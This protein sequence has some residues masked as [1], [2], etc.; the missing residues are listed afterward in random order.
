MVLNNS[1]ALRL[2]VAAGSGIHVMRLPLNI[3]TIESDVLAD[4][5][6]K[7]NDL[8]LPPPILISGVFILTYRSGR[9]G[10]ILAESD[11]RFYH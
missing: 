8:M 3:K 9:I 1:P 6:D 7:N 2:W 10:H 5:D 11:T 4:K